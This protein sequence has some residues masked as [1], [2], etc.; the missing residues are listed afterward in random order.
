MDSNA[1]MIVVSRLITDAR[2]RFGASNVEAVQVGPG[3]L[4]EAMDQVLAL[5]GEVTTDAC[6]VDGVQVGLLPD[7][8]ETPLVR[9]RDADD[10]Q[11]L[12]TD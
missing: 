4:D 3:L 2:T 11:P 8:V 6:V 9:L 7:G 12:T 5:G 10:P 1:A